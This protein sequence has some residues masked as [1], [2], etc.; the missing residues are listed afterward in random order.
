MSF[1]PCWCCLLM[2]ISSPAMN[3]GDV[4]TENDGVT[5][6]SHW[7]KQDSHDFLILLKKRDIVYANAKLDSLN[8]DQYVHSMKSSCTIKSSFK[9]FL[10]DGS[11]SKLLFHSTRGRNQS[12]VLD[13]TT[14]LNWEI[15][16]GIQ[17]RTARWASRWISSCSPRIIWP[18]L[19]S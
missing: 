13:W 3:A 12:L 4:I 18:P 1:F 9:V 6:I 2:L 16:K 17:S 19:F 7:S 8:N 14:S 10:N 5:I 11:D 15:Q